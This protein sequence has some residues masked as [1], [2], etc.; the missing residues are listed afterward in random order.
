LKSKIARGVPAGEQDR[1]ERDHAQH[2]ER[3]PQEG[4]DDVVGDGQEPLH[5]PQ[6]PGQMPVE[7]A[8]D[9]DRIRRSKHLC[10][11]LPSR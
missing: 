4:Q 5:Q 3:Q 11:L 1:E 9:A 2:D 7:R 8:V 6:P 10:H